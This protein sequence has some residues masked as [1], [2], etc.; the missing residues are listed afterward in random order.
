MIERLSCSN[1]LEIV[2]LIDPFNYDPP[3][4][5]RTIDL[6]TDPVPLKIQELSQ[7]DANHNGRQ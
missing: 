3:N 5:Y 1:K 4:Q 7:L 2:N 6:K